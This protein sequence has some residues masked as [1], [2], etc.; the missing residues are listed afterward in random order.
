MRGGGTNYIQQLR[1]E[2]ALKAQGG[3]RGVQGL[4]QNGAHQQGSRYPPSGSGYD[5]SG[6]HPQSAHPQSGFQR[7]SGGFS[8]VGAMRQHLDRSAPEPASF[9]TS[10]TYGYDRP[11][12][13]PRYVGYDD[14][15]SND[16]G[17]PSESEEGSSQTSATISMPQYPIGDGLSSHPE[18]S[19]V[20]ERVTVTVSPKAGRDAGLNRSVTPRRKTPNRRNRPGAPVVDKPVA[21]SN[22]YVDTMTEEAHSK[23]Y[24]GEQGSGP[25]QY[26]PAPQRVHPTRR[27]SVRRRSYEDDDVYS[28]I[29]SLTVSRSNSPADVGGYNATAAAVPHHD[30]MP[31]PQNTTLVPSRS[32]SPPRPR[33]RRD[34]G[35][36]PSPSRDSLLRDNTPELCTVIPRTSAVPKRSISGDPDATPHE[37]A[38]AIEALQRSQQAAMELALAAQ[39]TLL[40]Q[41]RSGGQQPPADSITSNNND[42]R[43]NIQRRPLDHTAPASSNAL[44]QQVSTTASTRATRSISPPAPAASLQSSAAFESAVS[45]AVEAYLQSRYGGAP[46]PSAVKAQQRSLSPP[47]SNSANT[48]QF[49][50]FDT[51][52]SVKSNLS[53]RSTSSLPPSVTEPPQYVIDHHSATFQRPKAFNKASKVSPISG[54]GRTLSPA[55]GTTAGTAGPLKHATN[56]QRHDDQGGGDLVQ[57]QNNR[58]ER[59]GSRRYGGMMSPSVSFISTKRTAPDS[60]PQS[61]IQ[62]GATTAVVTGKPFQRGVPSRSPSPASIMVTPSTSLQPT[63]FVSQRSASVDPKLQLADPILQSIRVHST[64]HNTRSA[65]AHS[66]DLGSRSVSAAVRG[67]PAESREGSTMDEIVKRSRFFGVGD[68]SGFGGFSLRDA[69]LEAEG[70]RTPS[71]S[72]AS[73]TGR[74]APRC[75]AVPEPQPL[76]TSTASVNQPTVKV[77]PSPATNRVDPIRMIRQEDVRQGTLGGSVG[78]EA[79]KLLSAVITAKRPQVPTHRASPLDTARRRPPFERPNWSPSPTRTV[80]EPSSQGGSPPRHPHPSALLFDTPPPTHTGSQVVAAEPRQPPYIDKPTLLPPPSVNLPNRMAGSPTKRPPPRRGVPPPPATVKDIPQ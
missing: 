39:Q 45:S 77:V 72:L 42:I 5:R 36:S 62:Q 20:S 70:S 4:H 25:R 55:P 9:P 2:F 51:N 8:Q 10:Y 6:G 67:P 50:R 56:D 18:R 16:G 23:E 47:S 14:G 11:A 38:A 66:M 31:D 69:A 33:G 1:E 78:E 7:D 37:I 15:G 71:S 57:S 3:P 22:R 41:R 59:V 80:E 35:K 13:R 52:H 75:D 27:Q 30:D 74:P 24:S 28:G 68:V 53:R 19:S 34:L 26:D 46:P 61:H 49:N 73:T 21:H 79:P 64:V 17:T 76:L 65:S 43:S 60:P 44:V 40:Q 48:P 54:R 29:S 58:S 32:E 63:P 12:Y